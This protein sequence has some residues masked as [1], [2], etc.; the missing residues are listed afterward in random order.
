MKAALKGTG[1]E[2]HEGCWN[3]TA[4]V[5]KRRCQLPGVSALDATFASPDLHRGGWLPLAGGLPGSWTW[6]LG[7]GHLPQ[8][9]ALLLDELNSGIP[10]TPKRST[11]LSHQTDQKI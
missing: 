6:I 3:P 5:S 4:A 11:G 7:L 1:K 9:A 8:E 2:P 10:D